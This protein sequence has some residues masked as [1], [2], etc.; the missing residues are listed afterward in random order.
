MER[1]QFVKLSGIAAGAMAATMIGGCASSASQNGPRDGKPKGHHGEGKPHFKE[2]MNKAQRVDTTPDESEA[3]AKFVV[4]SDTHVGY[5]Y[6]PYTDRAKNMFEDVAEFCPD[7]D[8]IIV[9]GDIT[10]H[11]MLEEY[12]TFASVA[13]AAGFAYPDDFVLVIGNHDQ[14]DSTEGAQPVS[15][16]TDLFRE[17]A[18][19]S[20]QVHPYYDRTINGVHLIM[21]GPDSYPNGNWA[22]FGI[23]DEQVQWMDS[24][25]AAD[26]E[27]G[28]LSFVFMHEPL[29]ETVRSTMPGDFGH[30]WSLSSEDNDNLH[31][32]IRRHDNVVF[33][34]GH[35]H[36][37]PDTVQLERDLGLYVGTG[38]VGYCV[39]D[40]DG[41]DSGYAPIEE[42]GSYGWEVTVWTTCI[43]FRLRN[44]LDRRF[45]DDLGTAIYQF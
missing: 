31:A 22:H 18:G 1:R 7:N 28:T 20:D 19:I 34:S 25:I 14:Y 24:L 39:T 27:S 30:E 40:P 32:H 21:L 26:K 12:E 38:S 9:N 8:A 13:E 23:S 36:S 6:P 11:G 43:K 2:A 35:T 42:Y 4:I 15:N 41:D 10:D 3:L 17:Q 16:L 37:M 45:E 33:F 29:F 44:F 5:N